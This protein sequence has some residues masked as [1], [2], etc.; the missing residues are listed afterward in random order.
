[1]P[2]LRDR[3]LA[4]GH[5]LE[6]REQG[7]EGIVIRLRVR[8]QEED[9]GIELVERTLEIIRVRHLHDAFDTELQSFVPDLD[10]CRDDD[11]V[12]RESASTVGLADEQKRQVRCIANS[13]CA[14]PDDERVRALLLRSPGLLPVRDLDEHGDPVAFGDRLT[15][16]AHRAGCY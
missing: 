14:R 7:L 6:K 11:C 10:I 1:M 16:P 12:G 13:N 3:E 8:A 5:V 4:R 9:L 2:Q 15:Q